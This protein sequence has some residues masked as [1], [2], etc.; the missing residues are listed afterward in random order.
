MKYSSLVNMVAEGRTHACACAAVMPLYEGM[1]RARDLAAA[2]LHQ[3]VSQPR[4]T[5]KP[6][7]RAKRHQRIPR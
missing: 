4:P 6:I 7:P 3:P 2:L 5:P 1:A